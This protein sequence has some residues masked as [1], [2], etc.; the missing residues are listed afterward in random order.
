LGFRARDSK[1]IDGKLVAPINQGFDPR[2]GENGRSPWASV[3][4]GKTSDAVKLVLP[5]NAA[6]M[7]LFVVDD[8]FGT[9]LVDV[10]PK[11]GLKPGDNNIQLIGKGGGGDSVATAIIEVREGTDTGK[12]IAKLYVMVLPPRTVSVGIYRI[13][14][15]RI[16]DNA[17]QVPS[18][19]PTLPTNDE[20]KSELNDLFAQAGVSFTISTDSKAVPNLPF[21][22]NGNGAVDAEDLNEIDNAVDGFNAPRCIVLAQVSGTTSDGSSFPR[23]IRTSDEA[24]KGCL[25]FVTNSGSYAATIAS[26]EIGH[27]L[28][29]SVY[30]P[31]DGPGVPAND[32]RHDPGPFPNGTFGLLQKGTGFNHPGRWL[33][34][35]DWKK[36][37]E[38]AKTP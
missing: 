7:K 8:G 30:G 17:T 37:N 12:L 31:S 4:E 28:N 18:Q 20:I 19:P 16:R 22:A 15:D 34:H 35:D 10:A 24:G 5:D 14:D 3:V 36:A 23:G 27:L 13:G 21:D 6:E 29:L 9:D 33:G 25:V 32:V 38:T 1:M 26:H 11:E 2:S